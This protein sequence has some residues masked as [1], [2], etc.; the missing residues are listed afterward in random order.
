[1]KTANQ[2]CRENPSLLGGFDNAQIIAEALNNDDRNSFI[3]ATQ[4]LPEDGYKLIKLL[5]ES[6]VPVRNQ[7]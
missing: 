6:I 2:I 7:R 3:N 1:M 4:L 5:C